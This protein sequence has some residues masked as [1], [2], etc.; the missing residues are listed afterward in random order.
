MGRVLAACALHHF[1][2][3]FD[4]DKRAGPLVHLDTDF[5]ET[6]AI[7]V[8]VPVIERKLVIVVFLVDA[9]HLLA[10][11]WLRREAV[12]AVGVAVGGSNRTV[13]ADPFL[14]LM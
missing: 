2:K 6:L 5:R 13:F 3:L 8:T 4:A 7:A 1:V 11:F 14:A 10:Q 12:H 9:D